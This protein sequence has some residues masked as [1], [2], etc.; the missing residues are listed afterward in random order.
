M[1]VGPF[2][3]L[4]PLERAQCSQLKDSFLPSRTRSLCIGIRSACRRELL[5]SWTSPTCAA[6]QSWESNCPVYRW[7]NRRAGSIGIQRSLVAQLEKLAVADVL[8]LD[9][10]KLSTSQVSGRSARS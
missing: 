6:C 3:D 9:S 1:F 2:H 10:P 7:R 5:P 4:S 8:H